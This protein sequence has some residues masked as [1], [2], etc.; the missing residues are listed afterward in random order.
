M[1]NG[2]AFNVVLMMCNT[3]NCRSIVIAFFSLSHL[4]Y[5]QQIITH[6]LNN[7]IMPQQGYRVVTGKLEFK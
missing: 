2:N 7:L 6:S 4:C 5:M 3:V 1:L